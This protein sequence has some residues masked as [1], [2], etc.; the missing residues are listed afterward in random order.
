MKIL[1][2]HFE[3]IPILGFLNKNKIQ[4]NIKIKKIIYRLIKEEIECRYISRI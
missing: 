1:Q 3:N 2:F 4:I